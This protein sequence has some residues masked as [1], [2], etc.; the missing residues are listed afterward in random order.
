MSASRPV[1]IC[2]K[3]RFCVSILPV[4]VAAGWQNSIFMSELPI[5]ESL[6]ER[7]ANTGLIC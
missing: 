7:Q 2:G 3:A 6:D 1:A 4:A 5:G